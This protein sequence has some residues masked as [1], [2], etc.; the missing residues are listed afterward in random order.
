MSDSSDRLDRVKPGSRMR[1]ELK[2]GEW[3]EGLFLR[4]E[5]GSVVLATGDGKK[6]VDRESITEIVATYVSEGPE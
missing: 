1:I 3:I 5:D 6:S 2:S 4:V